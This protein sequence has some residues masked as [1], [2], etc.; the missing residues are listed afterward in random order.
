MDKVEDTVVLKEKLENLREKLNQ[1]IVKNINCKSKEG[2][3][4]LLAASKE[5]DDIIVNY[6]KSFNNQV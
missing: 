5:L 2:C 6:I 4:N 1:N 3:E